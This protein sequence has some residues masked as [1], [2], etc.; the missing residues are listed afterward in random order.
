MGALCIYCGEDKSVA[1]T[2]VEVRVE[3]AGGALAPVPYGAEPED[4]GAGS[5]RRCGDCGVQPGG[6]HHPGCDIERCPVC[7]GQAI[8][9]ECVLESVASEPGEGSLLGR[10]ATAPADF[11]WP[12]G[13]TPNTLVWIAKT[14]SRGGDWIFSVFHDTNGDWQFGDG[15]E[16]TE[17]EWEA[18]PLRILF[19]L[20][21]SVSEVLD[22]SQGEFAWREQS[23]SAWRR[24]TFA[25]LP[26]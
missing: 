8:W 2:C 3:T 26:G 14:I 1:A 17:E 15:R 20:D 23:G 10:V 4:W 22:L 18:A 5:G 13:M 21:H 16:H 12:S 6:F 9:C 11:A 24:G 7:G 25:S 19:H